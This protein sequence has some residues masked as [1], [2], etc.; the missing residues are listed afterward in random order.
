MLAFPSGRL[1]DRP[2]RWI[3][4]AAYFDDRPRGAAVDVRPGGLAR[5]AGLRRPDPRARRRVDAAQHRIG[6]PHL[7][8][9]RRLP[10]LRAATPTARRVL[11]PVLGYGI[12]TAAVIVPV[13]VTS[14]SR[15]GH[16]PDH[17]G[18]DPARRAGGPAVRVRHRTAQ[19]DSPGRVSWSSSACGSEPTS[20]VPIWRWR[21]PT[22]SAT[23]ASTSASGCRTSA[24]MSTPPASPFPRVV[25]HRRGY[26]DIDL[27]G[28]HVGFIGTTPR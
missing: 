10:R 3:V 6:H 16:R 18:D 23:R 15:S 26:A 17:A 22:R 8:V 20:T 9:G 12:F 25:D 5:A 11:S 4:A 2:S 21:S 24:A 7:D 1:P 19:R 27:A 14:S 28:R 13:S